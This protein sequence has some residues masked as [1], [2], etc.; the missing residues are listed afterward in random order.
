MDKFE[1]RNSYYIKTNKICYKKIKQQQDWTEHFCEQISCAKWENTPR[2]AEP[3]SGW[4]Q[5][6]DQE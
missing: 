2:L 4:I 1:F 3:K 5:V 6:E